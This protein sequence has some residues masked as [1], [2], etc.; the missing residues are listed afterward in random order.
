[1]SACFSVGILVGPAI[2]AG[3]APIR[4]G[5]GQKR[6]CKASVTLLCPRHMAV[7]CVVLSCDF[8]L[9]QQCKASMP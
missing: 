9:G 7:M 4:A 3:L 6:W 5:E 1:M 8:E 2:G